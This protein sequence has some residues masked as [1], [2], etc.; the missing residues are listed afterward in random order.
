MR[1][2]VAIGAQNLN[3][4]PK[5]ALKKIRINL[6]K[7]EI[8]HRWVPQE[9]FHIT[10]SFLGETSPE[11]LPALKGVF[12]ELAQSHSPMTLK[13]REIGVFP[14]ERE[15]RVI[16]IGV[17]NSRELRSLQEDGTHRLKKLGLQLE[18]RP[19]VPHLTLVRLRNYRSL[20]DV[21][22]P[23]KN[24]DFGEMQVN[25][26]TLYESKLGGPYP[27]YEVLENFRLNTSL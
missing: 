2:F 19:Y 10:L 15:G 1:L 11:V 25:D 13:L 21:I 27:I 12:G 26:I 6:R 18:E 20:G 4:D 16:W 22:S 7:K 23:L 17:Q 24:T 8:D 5:E 9:N 14:S 3:F